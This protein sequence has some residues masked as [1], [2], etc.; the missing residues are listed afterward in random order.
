MLNDHPAELPVYARFPIRP[1]G[2]EG[3]WVWDQEGRRY[4]DFYGGH[5]VAVTGHCHPR[6]V[7]AVQEQAKK[8]LFYSNAVY[9]EARERFFDLLAEA[10]PG[11]LDKAFLVN[12]GAEANEQA[13]ALAR[14]A[15][16]RS[17]VVV[18]EGG[19]HGRT[20]ATLAAS[21][22]E[23][24]RKLA[25]F[26]RAG[27]DLLGFTDVC[28]FGD[29]GALERLVGEDTAAVFLEPVQGMGGARPAGRP[30]LETARRLC[31]ERG[32]AL[33]FDEV[34]C[35]TGRTGAF[36]AAQLYGVVPDALTLA[37]GIASG[38][39]L[40]VVLTG[41]RLA[42]GVGKGDLGSTFGGGPLP[43]AAGAATL[44]VLREERLPEKAA[45]MGTFLKKEISGL[46]GVKEVRGEGLLLGIVLDRP[47]GPVRE[48]LLEKHAVI[49]GSAI[50]PEV[51]R[52]LPPLTAGMEEAS[53]FLE[54]LRAA[55]KIPGSG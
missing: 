28:P 47:A 36:T 18:L 52:L 46:P 11:G 41:E 30:F 19:F 26:S 37:K 44:E 27:R 31:D 32:A 48:A 49:T 55:L 8:L 10:A 45:R 39:P 20:L 34:Q 25:A 35:G 15:T 12:S 16:G 22:I 29:E 54:N 1:A 23:K 9:L 2:G 38:L 51:L 5:A 14:R 7:E 53:L 40:G 50:Q 3:C 6:V 21:G 24:Y 43:C 4:L 33:L 17:R 42:A 13:L